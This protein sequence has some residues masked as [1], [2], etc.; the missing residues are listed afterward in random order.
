MRLRSAQAPRRSSA[1]RPFCAPG[2]S[3]LCVLGFGEL[4]GIPRARC[5]ASSNAAHDALYDA[6]Y[7]E[8]GILGTYKERHTNTNGHTN[9]DV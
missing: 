2:V 8:G 3:A 4:A 5:T 6:L 7:K 9:V 1:T